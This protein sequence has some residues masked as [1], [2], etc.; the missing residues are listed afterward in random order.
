MEYVIKKRLYDL[1]HNIKSRCNNH[2]NCNFRRYGGRGIKIEWLTF[3]EFFNDMSPTY[4]SGLTIERI[5]NNDNYSKNNCR[6][7]TRK[8][9]A[10]NRIT[11]RLIKFRGKKLTLTQWAENFGIKP[12]T[13]NQRLFYG[14]SVE[15]SLCQPIQ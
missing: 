10:N 13:L 6:W 7:A 3:N 8:E 12:K 2:K 15:R 1:Y 9:Q 4:K 5:N 14:W 11:N